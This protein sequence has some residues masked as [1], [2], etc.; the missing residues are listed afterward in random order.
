MQYEQ[1]LYK[2]FHLPTVEL[3]NKTNAGSDITEIEEL[4]MRII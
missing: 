2:H 4:R 1:E 3:Q